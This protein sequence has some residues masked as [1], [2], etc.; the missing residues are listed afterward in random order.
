MKQTT[1]YSQMDH[2]KTMESEPQQFFTKKSSLNVLQIYLATLEDHN[3]FKA[4]V[5]GAILAI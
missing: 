5:I 3:T 2:A 4:E 1:N